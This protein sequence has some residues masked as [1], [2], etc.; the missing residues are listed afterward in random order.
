[1]TSTTL[2]A[3]WRLWGRH[4]AGYHATNLALHLAEAL[5]LWRILRKLE[6][7]GALLG[8]ILFTVHPVN[9]ESVAWITQ[10]K[11]LMAMLFFL[12]SIGAFLRTEWAAGIHPA[13]W[14]RWRDGAW[15][16]WSLLAF[17]LAMLSKGSVAPLPVVL[18]GIVVWRRRRWSGGDSLRLAPFCA[19]AAGLVLVNLWF[20]IHGTGAPI[21]SVAPLQ[22]LLGAGGVVWFYLWKAVLPV[23]L[24]F[25]YP[26]WQILP[27]A[28]GGGRPCWAPWPSP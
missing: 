8:A 15:Y 6:I 14:S 18:A 22:R 28:W 11:N 19:V 23:K 20:Q 4:A 1:M 13:I 25:I 26:Q 16:A 17:A 9:V 10:R 5:L 7:P 27:A 2:W 12:L 3:E 24:S 21:R